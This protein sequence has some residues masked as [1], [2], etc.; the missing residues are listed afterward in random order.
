LFLVHLSQLSAEELVLNIED[1]FW[2][3]KNDYKVPQN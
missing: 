1:V 3:K 2:L